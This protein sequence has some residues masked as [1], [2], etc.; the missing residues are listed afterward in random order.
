M[1]INVKF[2]NTILDNGFVMIPNLLLDNQKELDLTDDEL[3]FIIKVMRHHE[4][5]KLH[6][7]QINEN[8]SSKTLQRRRKSLKD[9]GYLETTVYKYQNKDGT[10]IND[11]ILYDFS[12]LIL[13]LSEITPKKNLSPSGHSGEKIAHEVPLNNTNYNTT[14]NIFKFTEEFE[15]RY[16]TK[17]VLSSEEKLL[18]HNSTEEFKKS[19]PY[20]FDYVDSYKAMNKLDEEVVPR[21]MFFLKVPFRQKELI[22]FAQDI[23]FAEEKEEE[24]KQRNAENKVQQ[25]IFLPTIIKKG[26]NKDTLPLLMKEKGLTNLYYSFDYYTKSEIDLIKPIIEKLPDGYGKKFEGA[27]NGL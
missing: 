13:K 1:A 19:I 17:Y 27:T 9:K 20:I 18:L 5:F 25:S 15:K 12:G 4:S 8:L 21:L 23:L 22:S 10:W 26:L 6:D 11:G 24:Q 14:S 16:K 7:K 3:L 2:G